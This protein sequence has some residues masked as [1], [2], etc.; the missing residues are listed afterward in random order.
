MRWHEKTELKRGHRHKG[1]QSWDEMTCD[2]VW[3]AAHDECDV[4]G[5]VH[6]VWSVKSDESVRLASRCAGV[7]CSHVLGQQRN[8]FAQSTHARAWLAHG[9]CKFY[10]WERFYS[11]TLRQLLP[12]LVRALLV[13]FYDLLFCFTQDA[14]GLTSVNSDSGRL[15]PNFIRQNWPGKKNSDFLTG[16]S[17]F[18]KAHVSWMFLIIFGMKT[19]TLCNPKFFAKHQP[20][21]HRDSKAIRQWPWFHLLDTSAVWLCMLHLLPLRAT[22]LLCL[23]AERLGGQHV[24]KILRGSTLRDVPRTF[25]NKGYVVGTLEKSDVA[26]TLWASIFVCCVM[27]LFTLARAPNHNVYSILSFPAKYQVQ[28]MHDL[29]RPQP[30]HANLRTQKVTSVCG[31]CQQD[32]QAK[33]ALNM[34]RTCH[35]FSVLMQW[36]L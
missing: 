35:I 27:P 28:P 3:S 16:K 24:A 1:R 32:A 34:C 17:S 33:G 22:E 14:A 13:H 2:E 9:A 21:A 8:R 5:E 7:G 4:K 6:E 36:S 31:S 30:L 26:T 23:C 15:P 10:R 11:I 25:A 20:T 29:P 19:A 12:R 18:L